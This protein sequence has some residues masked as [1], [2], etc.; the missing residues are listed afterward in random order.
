MESAGLEMLHE[1]VIAAPDSR[2][3][4]SQW[5]QKHC[6]SLG[7]TGLPVMDV[8]TPCKTRQGVMRA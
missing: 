1:L 3:F 6:M 4:S 8:S 7:M 5:L 2:H